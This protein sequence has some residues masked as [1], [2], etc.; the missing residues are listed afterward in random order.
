MSRI[1]D[2]MEKAGLIAPTGESQTTE[3]F[4]SESEWEV[5]IAPAE[6]SDASG[7]T[8]ETERRA[9][10]H[11]ERR[12]R[13][14]QDPA[15]AKSGGKSPVFHTGAHVVTAEDFPGLSEEAS[16]QFD[17][18]L[19]ARPGMEFQSIEQFRRLG[20]MLHLMQEND[21][22]KTVLISSAVPAEGKTLTACNLA[23][24]LSG[25]YQRRVLLVD[26][27]LRRP[28]IH[29]LFQV[30]GAVGLSDWLRSD[31]T[32]GPTVERVSKRLSVLPAGR[33]DP[34]PMGILT[35]PRM[36][37]L[38]TDAE[39]SVDW[40]IFDSPPV[41]LL[42]DGHLLSRMADAVILVVQAGRTAHSDIQ[43]AVDSLG[44]ERIAGVVLN[45]VPQSTL[46]RGA[47]GYG[48]GYGDVNDAAQTTGPTDDKKSWL[49]RW[50]RA[51]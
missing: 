28:A 26:A 40:V 6:H 17:G 47:Y 13:V 3:L 25:S 46:A 9:P 4:P 24:C 37:E 32:A 43:H 19:L 48:Y 42:S 7:Q 33:P 10:G 20:A 31:S 23:L 22:V 5:E 16:H 1:D 34:D 11:R 30:P 51:S 27:D 44:R 35:S 36:Q 15:T 8:R 14:D 50:F 39:N 49:P 29:E 38:V 41:G 18:K 2:A 45:R 12:R 21:N